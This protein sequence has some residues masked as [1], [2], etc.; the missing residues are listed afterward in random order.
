[1]IGITAVRGTIISLEEQ[2]FLLLLEMDSLS[3]LSN[4]ERAAGPKYDL[5][6]I[7]EKK[8]EK[9]T[10]WLEQERLRLNKSALSRLIN[11][12]NVR[13]ESKKK[14][15]QTFPEDDTKRQKSVV[16]IETPVQQVPSSA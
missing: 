11:E 16:S 14:M 15:M 8:I 4:R 7:W 12:W 5:K 10:E 3:F 1:M 9:Q 6:T 2:F 13:L